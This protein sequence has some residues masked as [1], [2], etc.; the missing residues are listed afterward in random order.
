VVHALLFYLFSSKFGLNA[1]KQ[2]HLL[3]EIT[4][5]F[6]NVSNFVKK[7]IYKSICDKLLKEVE[8]YTIHFFC[9][10]LEKISYEIYSKTYV[11]RYDCY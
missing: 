7:L 11:Q 6:F 2:V 3:S 1:S 4:L 10:N 8:L 5:I 9:K